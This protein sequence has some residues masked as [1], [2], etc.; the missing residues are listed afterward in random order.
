MS[1]R[2]YPGDPFQQSLQ[3]KVQMAEKISALEKET[4]YEV[5]EKDFNQ[6]MDKVIEIQDKEEKRKKEKKTIK[7][8][9]EQDFSK[10][11]VR[12]QKCPN[13]GVKLKKC[14]C[15]LLL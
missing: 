9:V 15:G 12:N 7:N 6:I 8:T 4:G 3:A 14:M 5:T 11:S 10:G 2:M 13:C 1:R